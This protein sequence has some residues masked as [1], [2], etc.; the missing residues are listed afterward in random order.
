MRRLSIAIP[1]ARA[2]VALGGLLAGLAGLG[3]L[4]AGCGSGT[5]ARS[6]S[7]PPA[8]Q[9]ET[10]T[11][12][13]RSSR[14]HARSRSSSSATAVTVVTTTATATSTRTSTAPAFAQQDSGEGSLTAA[15][16]AVR[17]KGYTPID[18]AEYHRSQTLR[19]LTARRAGAAGANEQHAFFFVDGRYLGTDASQPSAS[20][21]VLSQGETTITLGYGLYREGDPST[22]PSGGEAS[23][24]FQL[25]NG[26]LTALDPIPP[27][28]SASGLA[29][30]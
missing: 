18:T 27:A 21:K 8:L 14:P 16:A 1:P 12:A 22:R 9:G 7:S 30:R 26:R 29:R 2:L 3:G 15:V 5:K 25:D 28:S 19:V 23:V 13:T 20:L 17:A 6:S 11:S 4:L 10:H 24:R